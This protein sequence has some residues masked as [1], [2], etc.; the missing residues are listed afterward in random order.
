M[1]LPS[2][3]LVHICVISHKISK[4]CTNTNPTSTKGF[5]DGDDG[6]LVVVVVVVGA[7][8]LL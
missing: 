7:F 8:C 6:W 1:K 4:Y 5:V 2:S 3:T